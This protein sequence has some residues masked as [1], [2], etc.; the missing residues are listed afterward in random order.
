MH[1]TIGDRQFEWQDGYG[2]FTVSA[3]LLATVKNY[4]AR[5]EDHHRKQTFKEEYLELLKRSGVE[6]DERY[7]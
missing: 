2:A 3:S 1:E 4:I 5:Q 7:L 6:F